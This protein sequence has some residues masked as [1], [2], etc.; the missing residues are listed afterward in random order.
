MKLVITGQNGFI[1]YHLYNSIKYK[2]TRIELLD[3]DKEFFNNNE[4][5]D[6]VFSNVD[7]I[8]HLAGLNR[9]DDQNTLYAT[10]KN[11]S[12]KIVESIK[13]VNFKGKLIFA[14]S[15]QEELQNAYG[16]AKKESR[17][18][19]HVESKKNGFSF[20]GLIIPNVY[21][22]FCKPNYNS[23]ISTFCCNSISDK[24]NLIIK[25]TK[26]PLIYIDNLVKK[27]LD[28]IEEESSSHIQIQEDIEVRVNEVKNIIEDFRKTYLKN[29]IIPLLDTTFKANLFKTF[30]SFLTL[31]D[32]FPKKLLAKKD[33]RGLF[34]EVVRS[35][36]QG[37]YSYS[38]T[39]P[40]E[41]RGNH[42]HTRKIERFIVISGTALI[43]LRKIG[44]TK[45]IIFELNGEEPSYIDMPIWFTHNIKNNGKTPLITLFWINEF[46]SEDNSDTYFEKV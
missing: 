43:E 9:L 6:K 2:N 12:C 23:F 41:T 4:D 40:G 39:E 26:V 1:G 33:S 20:T 18:L 15:I 42:F 35:N 5:L 22:P 8:I 46:F 11:L 36:I 24:E 44:S 34:S 38:L 25:D 21:G 17:E 37:Q 19:F 32:F 14:S 30:N 10:N 16:K 29:G 27:I 31:E 28:S 13:R 3:F 7:V 45:K